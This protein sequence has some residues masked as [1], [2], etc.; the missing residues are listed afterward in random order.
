MHS[1]GNP[2]LTRPKPLSRQGF[3]TLH[4]RLLSFRR[5]ARWVGGSPVSKF[6]VPVSVASRP[7]GHRVDHSAPESDVRPNGVAETPL[8]SV[9][10]AGTLS[11]I[12]EEIMFRGTVTGD[13]EQPC[14]R[15]LEPARKSVTQD[16]V[17]LFT[18]GTPSEPVKAPG[19]DDEDEEF[20]ASFDSERMRYF[21][22]DEVNLAPEVWE[23]MVLAAPVKFYCRETCK[24]LCPSCGKN[25][26][27]GACNCAQQEEANHS[28]LAALKDMF[29]NLPSK[30]AEE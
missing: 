16:V 11:A 20:D 10:L 6:L 30:A 24:G 9:R 17:W 5:L 28:G 15:C 7:G 23:E 1:N 21:A 26:N 29:P 25:L 13:F 12:D 14:D 22:N 4:P 8:K 2:A 18:P 3:D 19:E 27:E